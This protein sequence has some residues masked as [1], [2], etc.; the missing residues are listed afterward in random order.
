MAQSYPI[1]LALTSESFVVPLNSE[2]AL[3]KMRSSLQ[4][5]KA[6]PRMLHALEHLS[7]LGDQTLQRQCWV[8][9]A[10]FGPAQ[11]HRDQGRL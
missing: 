9:M 3:L 10:G 11:V 6:K 2:M 8:R 5:I 7:R 1:S 4:D